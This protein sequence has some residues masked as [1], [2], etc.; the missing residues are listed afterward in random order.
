MTTDIDSDRLEP[1]LAMHQ[2]VDTGR[3]HCVVYECMRGK[4]VLRA[5]TILGDALRHV[6]LAFDYDPEALL[7]VIQD[8][9][10][11][12]TSA[13]Y[14]IDPDTGKPALKAI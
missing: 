10:E 12:P 9:L 3:V 1:L 14:E 8:E 11:C 7:S 2:N 6:A 4:D 5:G 13:I